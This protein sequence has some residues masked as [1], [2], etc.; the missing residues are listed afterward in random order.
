M[1]RNLKIR[2]DENNG[3]PITQS[4]STEL[5]EQL[6]PLSDL[7]FGSSTHYEDEN[8]LGHILYMNCT[9]IATIGISGLVLCAIGSNLQDIAKIVNMDPTELGGKICFFRG[10]GSITGALVSSRVYHMI[11]G[12]KVLL[13]GLLTMCIVLVLI[14]SCWQTYQ[15]YMFF[16]VLGLC[17]AI[18]DTGCTIL[19]RKLRGQQAGPWLGANGISF[20]MSAAV[21][22]IVESLS[23]D[24]GKQYYILAAL[25]FAVAAS[26]WYGMQGIYTNE[27]MYTFMTMRNEK[28]ATYIEAR[29][30]I[31][32]IAPHYYVEYCVSFMVFCLVGGQVDMVAYIKSYVQQT[33]IVNNANKGNVLSIFWLFVSIGR[34]LGLV[35][36]SYIEDDSVLVRHMTVCCVLGTLF[37]LLVLIFPNSTSCFWISIAGYA[38]FYAPTVAYSHDLNNR[39]TLPTEKS[40][41]ICFFGLNVGASF[42]PF[43]TAN[44]W[45]WNQDS[46]STLMIVIL[47]SMCIPIPFALVVKRLSYKKVIPDDVFEA[48]RDASF[49]DIDS[50]RD[51]SEFKASASYIITSM[52]PRSQLFLLT[53]SSKS[54]RRA[55]NF[56]IPEDNSL[57]TPGSNSEITASPRSYQKVGRTFNY[58]EE[59]SLLT[60]F[61]DV[62]RFIR[63]YEAVSN[64]DVPLKI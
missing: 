27:E 11:Q 61:S 38:F 24:F 1:T 10:F 26:V 37:M 34:I 46:P 2:I 29:K 23:P 58:G 62:K 13:V 17:S 21:V 18:N 63:D 8:L 50:V 30:K 60:P 42:V 32:E 33:E 4:T 47:M 39:L 48:N 41:S 44:I 7:N 9:Y 3:S 55:F 56:I 6:T 25:I 45:K 49:Y 15:L 22:P 14:P 35:D 31:D 57:Y 52:T 12:D 51:F 19:T 64:K 28:T 36:Q 40:T 20:G 5:T 16:F 43:I 53:P 59:Q 54:S